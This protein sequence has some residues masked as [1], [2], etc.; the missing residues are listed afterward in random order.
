MYDLR[1][2]WVTNQAKRGISVVFTAKYADTSVMMIN[3]IYAKA[4]PGAMQEVAN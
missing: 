2:T 4:E 3:N 1:H